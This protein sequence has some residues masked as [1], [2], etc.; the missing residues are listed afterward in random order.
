MTTSTKICDCGHIETRHWIN[1]NDCGARVVGGCR[2][3]S[4]PC[5]KF[6]PQTPE[7][8]SKSTV[9]CKTSGDFPEDDLKQIFYKMYANLP[10]SVRNQIVAVVK[11]EPMTF[12]VIKLELDN[13]SDYGMEA[14]KQM[15]RL[16]II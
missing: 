9:D 6:Q 11:N 15:R 7:D 12:S 1:P 5:K 13:N 4:C 3:Y 10:I 16:N 14:I 2:I 8:S